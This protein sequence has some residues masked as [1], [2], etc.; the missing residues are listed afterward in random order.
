MDL[1]M[2]RYSV[3]QLQK[4]NS[5]RMYL[6]ALCVSDITTL[7]GKTIHAWA[8][9]G[10]RQCNSKYKWPYQEKPPMKSWGLWRTFLTYGLTLDKTHLLHPLATWIQTKRHISHNF[11]WSNTSD[12]LYS[13]TLNQLHSYQCDLSVH[14]HQYLNSSTLERII[15][16]NAI[17]VDVTK[18]L[19]IKSYIPQTH[20]LAQT[21]DHN[22]MMT[23]EKC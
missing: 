7:C 10:T 21:L 9:K 2:K 12:L 6:Q 22:P 16:D 1:P 8:M 14:Q 18:D 4:V 15:P 5:C 13:Q 3:K 11:L 19:R 23:F 20:N 17:P